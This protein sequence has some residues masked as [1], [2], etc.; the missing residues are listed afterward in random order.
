MR[1]GADAALELDTGAL[2]AQRVAGEPDC[3]TNRR[4]GIA[5]ADVHVAL[6]GVAKRI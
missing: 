4:P 1:A 2:P 5:R 3:R 6:A